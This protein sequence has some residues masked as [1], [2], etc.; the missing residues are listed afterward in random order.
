[1]ALSISGVVVDGFAALATLAAVIA[2]F[3]VQARQARSDRALAISARAKVLFCAADAARDALNSVMRAR[4]WA[5][6]A[7]G[8]PFTLREDLTHHAEVLGY[9][10]TREISDV[11]LVRNMVQVRTIAA[12]ARTNLAEWF[13]QDAGLQYQARQTLAIAVVQRTAEIA[14]LQAQLDRQA[15]D[16]STAADLKEGV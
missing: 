13:Q 2:A 11:N 5:S 4:Y 15:V 3:V 7:E 14:E 16:F 12:E 8:D 10:F 6:G 1:M 9:Y